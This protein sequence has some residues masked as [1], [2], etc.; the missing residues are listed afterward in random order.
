VGFLDKTSSLRRAL[1]FLAL[2]LIA[3]VD[4]NGLFALEVVDEQHGFRFSVPSGFE[5]QPAADF[6]FNPP[7]IVTIKAF[8]E[9][10]DESQIIIVLERLSGMV[11]PS[12]R[13]APETLSQ[14]DDLKLSLLTRQWQGIELQ[15]MR[16]YDTS[17]NSAYIGFIIQ[18]PLRKNAIQLRVI[19][20]AIREADVVDTFNKAIGSFENTKTF[21]VNIETANRVTLR[22]EI[23]IAIE[24][25]FA[26]A[27]VGAFIW[28]ALAQRKS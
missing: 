15:G 28:F 21:V 23:R 14:N 25:V 17:S 7:S 27:I 2:C 20:P 26:C 6:V 12:D 19:G 1:S 8:A 5:E 11:N 3:C 22:K 18:F 16:Q 4:T 9:S 10:V 13:I 24:V